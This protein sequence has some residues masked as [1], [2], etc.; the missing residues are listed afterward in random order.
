MRFSEKKTQ[1]STVYS[2]SAKLNKFVVVIVLVSIVVD[3]APVMVLA[4]DAAAVPVIAANNFV[5][6]HAQGGFAP[7]R[8][9]RADGA[10]MLHLPRAGLVPV[11]AGR[12]RTDRA[13]VDT[14]TA[15][16]ALKMVS[17]RRD[18]LRINTAIGD[19]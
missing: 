2:E 9:M 16:V 12:Q 11:D 17:V 10:D 19:A 6:P 8:T 3:A 14:A 7:V 13:D 15:F 5:I 18:D 1:L 4:V